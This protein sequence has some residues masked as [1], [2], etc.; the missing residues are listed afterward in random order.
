MEKDQVANLGRWLAQ[1]RER[2]SWSRAT[3]AARTEI[4]ERNQIEIENGRRSR[5]NDDTIDGIR[6][7]FGIT[8]RQLRDIMDGHAVPVPDRPPEPARPNHTA[9]GQVWDELTDLRRRLVESETRTQ[10]SLDE[11]RRVL[12]RALSGLAEVQAEIDRRLPDG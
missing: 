12:D 5:I 7:G 3:V 6:R 4:S 9:D 2:W 8:D 11:F 10:I 1:A